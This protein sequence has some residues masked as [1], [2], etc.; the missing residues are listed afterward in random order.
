MVKSQYARQTLIRKPLHAEL[1][2]DSIR[3]WFDD[4]YGECSVVAYTTRDY[5]ALIN[6]IGDEDEAY[7]FKMAFSDLQA[8]FDMFYESLECDW[9]PE[10]FDLLFAVSGDCDNTF[11]YEDCAMDIIRMDRYELSEQQRKGREKLKRMTKDELLDAFK[12]CLTIATNY[13]SLRSRYD[14]LKATMD[15]ILEKNGTILE[16]IKSIDRLYEQAWERY[17]VK[18]PLF[19]DSQ[20]D[21]EEIWKEFNNALQY[22]PQEAFIA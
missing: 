7:E 1:N 9:I 12:Q 17:Y 20:W 19:R 14:A 15:V 22:L 18:S 8:Q 16:A 21:R 5:D 4:A 11:M 13:M 3:E 10:C 2:L 6:A